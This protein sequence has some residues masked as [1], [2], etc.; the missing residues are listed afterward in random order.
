MVLL[1]GVGVRT[2]EVSTQLKEGG[3]GNEQWAEPPAW[4]GYTVASSSHHP[5]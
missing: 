2:T 4:E 1:L 5:S 3:T